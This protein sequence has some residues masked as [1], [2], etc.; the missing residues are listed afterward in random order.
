MGAY[1][2]AKEPPFA[3]TAMSQSPI[4][5]KNFYHG[6]EYTMIKPCR[7][8]FP[9]GIVIDDQCVWV[10]F[11]RQDHEVWMA[12]LDKRGLYANLIPVIPKQ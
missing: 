2:F 6:P 3:I 10:V 5:G 8:V 12:K 1:T 7:V 9:C 4:I 11:G